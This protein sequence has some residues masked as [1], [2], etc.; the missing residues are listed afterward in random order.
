MYASIS[1]PFSAKQK[2]AFSNG[3]QHFGDGFSCRAMAGVSCALKLELALVREV[4]QQPLI[5]VFEGVLTAS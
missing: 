5:C 3:A 4:F 2:F 1:R